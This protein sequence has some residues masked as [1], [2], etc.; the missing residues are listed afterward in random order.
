MSSF[1][2]DPFTT[3]LS[4][5]QQTRGSSV[6]AGAVGVPRT[7][8]LPLAPG[9]M[10][11]EGRHRSQRA[12]RPTLPRPPH[13]GQPRGPGGP[14]GSNHL[15]PRGGF[16]VKPDQT[17]SALCAHSPLTELPS[18]RHRWLAPM[19]GKV[20]WEWLSDLYLLI[21][22]VFIKHLLCAEAGAGEGSYEQ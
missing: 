19:V 3:C 2:R 11:R 5:M 13:W 4:T 21:E 10:C 15:P 1:I 22:P 9:G 20:E 8:E 18:G 16:Q 7:P 12:R 14:P 6:G 17:P